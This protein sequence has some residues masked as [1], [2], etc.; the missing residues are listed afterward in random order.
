[1]AKAYQE[2]QLAIRLGTETDAL[3]KV[4]SLVARHD[5]NVLAYCLYS[6]W[7]EPVLLL[8]TTDPHK[9]RLTLQS[10]GFPCRTD[11]IVMV[12]AADQV[13]V[14]ARLGTVLGDAGVNILYSYACSA[15]GSHFYAV[16]KT[17]DDERTLRL[18]RELPATQAA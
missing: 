16:F 1:M 15:G 7:D 14:V 4:L 18:L 6:E 10:A 11:S 13:G 12:S 9:A 17:A 8:V 2:V 3:A 5:V